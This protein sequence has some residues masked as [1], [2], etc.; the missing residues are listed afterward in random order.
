MSSNI[1]GSALHQH[2]QRL[3]KVKGTGKSV[4]EAQERHRHV[5]RD[6]QYPQ[7]ANYSLVRSELLF[8]MGA[9]EQWCTEAALTFSKVVP[10]NFSI[11]TC[12]R[13]GYG[14]CHVHQSQIPA[15][16]L[17]QCSQRAS[18][19]REQGACLE[20]GALHR[21]CGAQH[22]APLLTAAYIN[23]AAFSCSLPLLILAQ[24][25]PSKIHTHNNPLRKQ[26]KAPSVRTHAHAH[27]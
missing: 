15:E 24:N 7:T 6:P 8:V 10:L 25:T 19:F 13:A 11:S 26:N 5:Q 9:A 14:A 20:P 4:A 3:T 12:L 21:G 22:A 18:G 1:S 16:R 2:L 27:T 23:R 17:R